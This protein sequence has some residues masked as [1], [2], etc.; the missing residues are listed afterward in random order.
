MKPNTQQRY[1]NR[2]ESQQNKVILANLIELEDQ[3]KQ[4]LIKSNKI[5]KEQVVSV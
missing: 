5:I 4:A 3:G 2:N 1:L